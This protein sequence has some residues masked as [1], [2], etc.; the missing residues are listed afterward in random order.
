M[1]LPAIAFG[2]EQPFGALTGWN[3]NSA[4][5]TNGKER[6]SAL[7]RIGNEAAS[8]LYDEKDEVTASFISASSSVAPT[9]PPVIGAVL[10]GYIL[11]SIQVS[12]TRDGMPTMTLTGHQHAANPH[13]GSEK[14][15]AH[16]ITIA[17]GFGAQDF[18]SGTAGANASVR[19]GSITIECQH[20]DET[21]ADGDHLVGENYTPMIT[22]ETEWTGVPTT[23]A[24]TGWDV[25]SK[26]NP[27]V[28]TGF[29]SYSVSG[30][31]A[32]AF[33]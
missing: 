28:N 25:T 19:S 23:P 6:A 14:K 21:D 7:D 11:T 3:Y 2:S 12:T 1:T 33:A 17:S 15:I 16:G 10:N 5:V 8:K 9:I 18:M 20:A 24:A 29:E 4:S 22:A 31:K 26:P 13:D 30:T 27:T 32:L